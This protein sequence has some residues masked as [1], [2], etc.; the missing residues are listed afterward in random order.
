LVFDERCKQNLTG[1]IHKPD[2]K[3]YGTIGIITN[4]PGLR[5]FLQ[6]AS[7]KQLKDGQFIV[8]TAGRD[9]SI[10]ELSSFREIEQYVSHI[11]LQVPEE[12]NQKIDEIMS[13]TPEKDGISGWMSFRL[14]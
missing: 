5:T 13:M 14:V 9:G 6:L 11:P 3:K 10:S 2:V 8:L 1:Y 7:E 12:I 4:P